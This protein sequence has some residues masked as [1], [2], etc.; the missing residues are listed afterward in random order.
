MENTKKIRTETTLKKSR[1]VVQPKISTFLPKERTSVRKSTQAKSEEVK[2]RIIEEAAEQKNKKKKI[3]THYENLTQEQLLAE[4]MKT[5]IINAKSLECYKRLELERK[6]TKFVKNTYSGPIIRYHSVTMPLIEEIPSQNPENLK[7]KKCSRNFVTF[8]D[9][10]ALKTFFPKQK[11]KLITKT[12]CPITRLR[13]KYFD[14]VTQIHYANLQAFRVLREAYY[15][16]LELK[17]DVRQPEVAAWLEWRKKNRPQPRQHKAK[18]PA[19]ANSVPN[20]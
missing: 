2:R 12:P 18:V 15:Q 9:D 13:A 11:P 14:P 19:V 16:Q 20:S 8:T 6:K 17:G 1:Y 4:A 7:S 5:E 3:V 10:K